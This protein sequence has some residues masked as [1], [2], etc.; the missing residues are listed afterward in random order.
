MRRHVNGI[1][2]LDKPADISSNGA[3]QRAKRIF[4]AIKAG[5]TGSLDPIAT[6]ILPICFGEA[7]KFSQ[8]L[9]E[10]DKT[11]E[12]TA[13]LGEQTT[14]GDTEG[15]IIATHCTREVTAE[16]IN[17]VMQRY[18]GE[19]EQVPPMY[20]AL[21]YQGKPLYELARKGI[22]V[23][24]KSRVVKVFNIELQNFENDVLK[25]HV[26]CSKGTYVRTLVEDIGKDL[27]CYGHVTALRR[28]SIASYGMTAK[29][30]TISELLDTYERE[31]FI[32][33]D[34]CLLP[35]D[36]AVESFPVVQLSSSAAFYLKMGQSVRI[37]FITT[38][39]L[40]RL[41]SEEQKFLGIGE[42]LGDGRVKPHR[43]VA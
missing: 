30:H 2:L 25:F 4:N 41:V 33:L 18:L 16:K 10:S 5:H 38:S 27:G 37:N 29:I 36:T 8:Y 15:E 24:R 1:L 35:V 3:L 23:E 19:I 13:K 12:V 11:Y 42:V 9:L 6:G 32:G 26:H 17:A 31:G 39:P 34:K 40:V 7:T 28:S 22:V 20:S 21:K 43:L 14:T